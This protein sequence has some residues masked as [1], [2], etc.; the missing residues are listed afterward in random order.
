MSNQKHKLPTDDNETASRSQ[1][2]GPG[3]QFGNFRAEKRLGT[4][5]S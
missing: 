5:G 4:Q 2:A 1:P 3:S